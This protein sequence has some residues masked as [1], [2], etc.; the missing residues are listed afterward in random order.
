MRQN[1]LNNNEHDILDFKSFIPWSIPTYKEEN[2]LLC[3]R[4]SHTID[5][6]QEARK[7]YG[8]RTRIFDKNK[9]INTL[10]PIFLLDEKEEPI[11]VNIL[12]VLNEKPMT[13]TFQRRKAILLLK[14]KI[15]KTTNIAPHLQHLI[16]NL[17]KLKSQK[18]LEYYKIENN[19]TLLLVIQER[20][21]G[22]FAF[23]SSAY[24]RLE[25]G[26]TQMIKDLRCGDVVKTEKGLSKVLKIT[27]MRNEEIAVIQTEKRTVKCTLNQTFFV[28]NERIKAVSPTNPLAIGHLIKGDYL[29]NENGEKEII[30]NIMI[31]KAESPMEVYVLEFEGNPCVFIDGVLVS[32]QKIFIKISQNKILCL[33]F[34]E[35]LSIQTLKK[36]ISL[37]ENIPLDCIE[38][39]HGARLLLDHFRLSD[40]NI[41]RETLLRVSIKPK[42]QNWELG[43]RMPSGKCLPLNVSEDCFVDALVNIVKQIE[44][45][46]IEKQ[47]LIYRATGQILQLGN[48]L[49]SYN[50]PNRTY[51]HLEII[52]SINSSSFILNYQTPESKTFSLS[53]DSQSSIQ[54][55]K[56][57]I[58]TQ[59]GYS[60][61][62]HYLVYNGWELSDDRTISETKLQENALVFLVPKTNEESYKPKKISIFVKLPWGRTVTLNTSVFV[63][64]EDIKMW[65][66]QM[67]NLYHYQKLEFWRDDKL[68][69]NKSAIISNGIQGGDT[70]DL[71]ISDIVSV[72]CLD[73]I[74]Q[75]DIYRIR[76]NPNS[77]VKELRDLIS[78]LTNLS[79]KLINFVFRDSILYQNDWLLGDCFPVGSLILVVP[80]HEGGS[81]IA[82]A[83]GI[84]EIPFKGIDFLEKSLHF[85]PQH[86][87][88]KQFFTDFDFYFQ[89]TKSI[90]EN[91]GLRDDEIGAL[92]I[93]STN[94]IY[95]D[96]NRDLI[97]DQELSQWKY[98]L[99]CL[100]SGIRKLPYHRGVFYRGIKNFSI[101]RSEYYEGAI[102]QWKT[103]SAMSKS[104]SSIKTYTNEK[105]ALFEVD[106]ATC[107]DISKI[108][109]FPKEEEVLL[110]PF[111]TLLVEKVE[112]IPEKPIYI[113]L[114]EFNVPRSLKVVFWVD[115]QPLQNYKYAHELES[116]GVSVL[117]CTSTKE[118]FSLISLYRWLLYF[119]NAAF[120]IVTDMTRFEDGKENPFAG[121]DL[122]EGLCMKF[123][124]SF[125]IFCYC[126]NVEKALKNCEDRKLKGNFKISNKVLELKQYL[127][128]E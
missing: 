60:P 49:T 83:Q 114:K 97:T 128:F 105:G 5:L 110:E 52:N 74:L 88:I 82:L 112:E 113:K 89:S 50:I 18:T 43:I 120:K 102:V 101:N 56:E 73:L 63:L 37:R 121:V 69:S 41:Q 25:N 123:K 106:A 127:V 40:Y 36:N 1:F 90:F 96:I 2:I 85:L 8:A 38:L 57:A 70:I 119:P 116:Q 10:S 30:Q 47:I 87:A 118:A 107:R 39:K 95:R 11:T 3:L 33:D 46:P 29:L 35:S 22:C 58:W 91:L 124:F 32:N 84:N 21:G 9:P 117:F 53:M 17:K 77:R 108:S 92:V 86:S 111:A 72:Y 79:Q 59:S 4:N 76:L 100:C 27:V 61:A 71:K 44:N 103:I 104:L 7:S 80:S 51:L 23:P 122:I 125:D 75:N 68:L 78:T 109:I 66:V 14:T 93:W 28:S 45:I 15:E 26:Q 6:K 55:L 115:D 31:Y 16:Y 81:S 65:I 64:L 42:N 126:W 48:K 99:K 12:S 34:D 13:F 24:L 19:D 20:A 67:E 98:F 62:L 94:L 54:Q